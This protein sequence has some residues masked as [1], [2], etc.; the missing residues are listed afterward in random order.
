MTTVSLGSPSNRRSRLQAARCVIDDRHA[1]ARPSGVTVPEHHDDMP[2]GTRER[3]SKRCPSKSIPFPRPAHGAPR[4]RS[5][6]SIDSPAAMRRTSNRRCECSY[7][8]PRWIRLSAP[9]HGPKGWTYWRAPDLGWGRR[10]D[11]S[12]DWQVCPSASV[13]CEER[14]VATTASDA[15]PCVDG[16]DRRSNR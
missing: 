9:P 14:P 15:L 16:V 8:W 4:L 12:C 13:R 1:P 6:T 11:V 2:A 5:H 3:H 7:L 10:E